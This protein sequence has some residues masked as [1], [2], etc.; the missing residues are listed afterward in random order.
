MGRLSEKRRGLLTSQDDRTKLT[1]S[2]GKLAS[3]MAV[4]NTARIRLFATHSHNPLVV[5]KAF[6]FAIILAK[7]LVLLVPRVAHS[8]TIAMI[9]G[10][11]FFTAH[12]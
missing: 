4:F 5:Y 3:P 9:S 8:A 1:D 10:C 12:T 2:N 11:Y 7:I 6:Q